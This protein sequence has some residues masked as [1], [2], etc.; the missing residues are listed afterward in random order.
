[1]VPAE[2]VTSLALEVFASPGEPTWDTGDAELVGR[3]VEDLA[4]IGWIQRTD[5]THSWVLRVPNAYPV[6]NLGYRD[7]L[8]RVRGAL[9]RFP[10]LRL[11]GRTGAFSYMN[12][13]GVVEDCFRLA[14]ELG[15]SGDAGIRPLDADAGRWV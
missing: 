13:D 12:V 3:A 11:L 1:M 6:Q 8:A 9:A 5:V 15:L 2:P 14:R 7:R 10:R 4:G